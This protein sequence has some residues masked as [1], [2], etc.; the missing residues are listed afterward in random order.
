MKVEKLLAP[1]FSIPRDPSNAA[2]IAGIRYENKI[3]K[4]LVASG[5]DVE[6]NPWF[7]YGSRYCCPDI[8]LYRLAQGIAIVIEVK[9][10]YCPD[11]ISKLKAVYL[12]VLSASTQLYQ[13]KP[14]II[15]RN[16]IPGVAP[17][18][19]L[20][21]ALNQPIPLIHWIGRGPIFPA[22]GRANTISQTPLG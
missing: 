16:L 18:P 6:H 12:P 17:A 4:T 8:I 19:S 20:S 5:D 11:A 9:L 1:P 10:T 3:F 7:R 21:E 2:S 15:A 22:E 13:F 14:L